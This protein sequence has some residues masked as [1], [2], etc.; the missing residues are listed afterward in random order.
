MGMRDRVLKSVSFLKGK[1]IE[2]VDVGIILGSGLGGEVRGA[3]IILSYSDIPGFPVSTV[4]GHKGELLF[5][6]RKEKKILIFSGRFH[7]YE[8]YDI[9]EVVYPVRVLGLLGGRL[10]IVTNA[11]GGVSDKVKQGDIVLIE[12]HIHLIPA[13]PLRGEVGL[14]FG[15]RFIPMVN[16]YDKNLREFALEFA[17]KKG[18]SLKCGVYLSLQGPSFETLAEYKMVKILGADMV[19][20]STTPEVIAA[21]QMNIKVLGFSVIT[22]EGKPGLAERTDHKE[23]IK[24]AREK[25]KILLDFI[26]EL[27]DEIDLQ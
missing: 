6:K 7:Y 1:G 15:E 20:M 11:A 17:T 25:G 24:V 13:N 9:S 10:L 8:G 21:R 22:N 3:E 2:R 16:A 27:L 26:L 12:D 18:L 14:E 23:V 5:L 4:E 19:G